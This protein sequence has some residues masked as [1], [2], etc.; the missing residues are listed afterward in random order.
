MLVSTAKEDFICKLESVLKASGIARNTLISEMSIFA[1]NVSLDIVS[2]INHVLK[3]RF[4]DVRLRPMESVVNAMIHSMR[5]PL[6]AKFLTAKITT[7][8][9]V[10][11]VNVDII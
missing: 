3:I 4:L 8:T 7:N 5:N 11:S 9:D 6:D 1:P 10:R 2:W